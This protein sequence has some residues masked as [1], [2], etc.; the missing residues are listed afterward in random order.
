M[1]LEAWVQ[2]GAMTIALVCLINKRKGMIKYLPVGLF[3]YYYSQIVCQVVMGIFEFWSYPY[4]VFAFEDTS[5]PAN[6]VVIPIMAMF[7]IRYMPSGIRNRMLWWLS[8]S[9]VLT[10]FEYFAEK[11]TGLI[12]YH[13]GYNS[14]YTGV[15][16]LISWT[17]FYNFHRWFWKRYQTD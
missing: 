11:H 5:I 2:Y 7:W 6:A 9:T 3:A 17:I 14:L 16:W 4:R 12:T 8:W 10:T 13:N 15:L 1:P